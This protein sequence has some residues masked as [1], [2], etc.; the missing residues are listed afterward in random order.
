MSDRFTGILYFPE[1]ALENPEAKKALIDYFGEPSSWVME[2]YQGVLKFQNDYASFGTFYNI[3][4]CFQK[5]KIPYDRWSDSCGEYQ[6]ETSHYRPELNEIVSCD[7]QD[8]FTVYADDIEK[9]LDSPNLKEEL[10]KLLPPKYKD[11][12]E[13]VN[14]ERSDSKQDQENWFKEF[15]KGNYTFERNTEQPTEDFPI[16]GLCKLFNR[17]EL[18]GLHA[19]CGDWAVY[20]DISASSGWWNLSFAEEPVARCV[21]SEDFGPRGQYGNIERVNDKVSDKN[22]SDICDIITSVCELYRMAPEEREKINVNQ[23]MKGR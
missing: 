17:Y 1:W 23:Q 3:E 18:D 20:K 14:P 22:F 9:I 4:K 7:G 2:N 10:R 15:S 6:A 13:Y 16:D 8:R 5:N 11:L 21:P 12:E 19:Y